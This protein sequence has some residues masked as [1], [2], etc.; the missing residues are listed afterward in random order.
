MRVAVPCE[1]DR[2]SAHFGHAAQF[3]FFDTDRDR[4]TIEKEETLASP[5]HQPGLL[6]QWIAEQGATVVLATGMGGR[7]LQRFAEHGVSVVV[8]VTMSDPRQAVEA[9]LRGE[10]QAGANVCDHGGGGGGRGR[11]RWGRQ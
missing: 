1:E 6:P 3:T 10:L 8:G 2:I 7:A 11:G 4:G 9:Y 5:P